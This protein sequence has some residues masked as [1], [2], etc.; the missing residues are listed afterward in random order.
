MKKILPLILAV[1]FASNVFAQSNNDIGKIALSVVMPENVDGLTASQLSKLET[2]ISQ[3]V[4]TAG[5][6]ASGYDNNFIV[7][8]KF[9]IYE[10]NVVEGDMQNL[11]V[12]STEISLFIKQVENNIMYSSISKSLK[13]S[14]KNKEIALTNAIS[15][16]STNDPVFGKFIE[17]GKT[18]IIKYYEAK[19]ED[20][21]KKSDGL[22]K[23]QK[24]DEALG[25][26]MTVPEEVSSCYHLIQDKTINAY[27]AYQ[28]QKCSE[29]IQKAKTTFA[30]NDM[31]GT[32]TL[33]AEIDP[34]AS[35]FQ[36]AQAIANKA[37]DKVTALEKRQ[38]DLQKQEWDFQMKQYSDGVELEKQRVNAVKEIAVAYYKRKPRTINY[39][40]I[41]R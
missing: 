29:Q 4:T 39:N 9:A 2:K 15:K 17:E 38:W 37:G 18:K 7:Y 19:C 22:V 31:P 21:V 3:I 33:L 27:K 8:P 34:S 10:T 16:I 26:L 24:Y 40:Y 32:L 23:M 6:G 28:T 35:C 5:L 36:E 12:I 30:N 14:G 1:V 25:L 41:I 13:G 11:T 20:I